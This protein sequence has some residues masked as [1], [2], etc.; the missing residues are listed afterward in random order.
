MTPPSPPTQAI[1]SAPKAR[2]NGTP[3]STTSPRTKSPSGKC[4]SSS[5]S[6]SRIHGCAS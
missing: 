4:A 5:S 3:S 6:S 2:K 1:A